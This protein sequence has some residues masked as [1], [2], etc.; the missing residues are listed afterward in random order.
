[1]QIKTETKNI[2]DNTNVIFDI[3]GK[4]LYNSLIKK[5]K[6]ENLMIYQLDKKIL[7]RTKI[8]MLI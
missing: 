4:D 8:Q 2:I 3:K 6:K 5:V 7:I 1:M